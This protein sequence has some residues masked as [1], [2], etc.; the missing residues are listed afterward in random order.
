MGTNKGN[1]CNPYRITRTSR[2]PLG[3]G[4]A[5]KKTQKNPWRGPAGR[6]TRGGEPGFRQNHGPIEAA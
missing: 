6:G 4:L 5:C 2:L 1:L 3:M